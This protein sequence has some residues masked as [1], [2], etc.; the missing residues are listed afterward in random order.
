[1]SY[2]TRALMSPMLPGGKPIP[3]SVSVVLPCVV[4]AHPAPSSLSQKSRG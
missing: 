1:M 3:D 4:L 2:P